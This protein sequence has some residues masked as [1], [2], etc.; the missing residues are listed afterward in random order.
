MERKVHSEI[1]L[2]SFKISILGAQSRWILLTIYF[3]MAPILLIDSHSFESLIDLLTS[4]LLP[5][6]SLAP[7]P[8]SLERT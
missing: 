3:S 2:Q 6:A 5:P 7:S 1:N 8:S 4:S